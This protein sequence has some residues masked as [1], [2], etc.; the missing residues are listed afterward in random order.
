[1]SL[2]YIS[3]PGSPAPDRI[4]G[5]AGRGRAFSLDLRAGERLVDGVA[6]GFAA[7]GFDSGTV[8]LHGLSL[9]PFAYVMPAPSKSPSNAAFY[10]ETFRPAGS[11]VV[12]C[13][14]MSFGRRDN[15]PFFHA[16]GLWRE[17][18]GRPSGGH[19]LPDETRVAAP[20]RLEAFGFSGMRFEA[21][22]DAEINFTVFGPVAVAASAST[23]GMVHALR[24]RPNQCLHRALEI[25]AAEH[26]IQRAR[27][28]G[29]VG[30]TIGAVFD[31]GRTLPGA[32][33]ELYVARGGIARDDA[34]QPVATIEVGIVDH[35][36]NQA[37]GRLGRGANAV[38][39]TIEIALE[40]IG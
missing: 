34:G 24:L 16:H 29:G 13:G 40:V 35:L 19:I 7:A 26:G 5:V 15:A 14:Q 30:S 18:D 22:P 36:G 27:L 3:Q 20:C 28:S 12:S 21:A 39:M 10:S 2:P 1:M 17:A 37:V 23:G 11:A 33:T 9:A 38:L 32:F 25:Y 6:A 8:A 31:D 4:I